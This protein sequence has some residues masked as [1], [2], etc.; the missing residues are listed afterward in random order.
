[1]FDKIDNLS[2]ILSSHMSMNTNLKGLVNQ[3]KLAPENFLMPLFEAVVNSVQSIEEAGMKMTS[4]QISIDIIRSNEL[5]LTDSNKKDKDIPIEASIHGFKI[6]DN[7]IGFDNNN[8]D[9]FQLLATEHKIKFGCKGFG[10]LT[11]LKVFNKIRIESIYKDGNQ[12]IKRSFDFN[13]SN[14][15]TNEQK[16]QV[17]IQPTKTT[18]ELMGIKTEYKNYIPRDIETIAT[19]IIEHCIWYYIRDSNAPN[20]IVRDGSKVI[21][22]HQLYE[23]LVPNLTAKAFK[24]GKHQFEIT[25]VKFYGKSFEYQNNMIF[26]AA[27]RIVEKAKL[28]DKII[29]GLTNKITESGATP[30]DANKTFTYSCFITSKFFNEH[31]NMERTRINFQQERDLINADEDILL[32]KDTVQSYINVQCNEFLKEYLKDRVALGQKK[33]ENYVNSTGVRYKSILK[34]ISDDE[35]YI[36]PDA[37]EKDIELKL[38]NHLYELEKEILT[39]GHMIMEPAIDE[40]FVQYK[41]RLSNYLDKVEDMKQSDL[42][43]YITHRKVII[44]IFRKALEIRKDGKY[45]LEDVIHE[46]IVPMHIDSENKD[47]IRSNLWLIDERLNFHNYMSSDIPLKKVHVSESKSQDRPDLFFLL[48]NPLLLTEEKSKEVSK[49]SIIIVEFKRPMRN[50]SK[51]KIE[52]P[53]RQTLRYL[54]QIKSEKLT[55]ARG[56]PINN[57]QDIPAY[58]FIVCDLTEKIKDECRMNGYTAT[59]DKEGYFYH[60]SSHRAYLEVISYK[61]LVQDAAKRNHAFFDK[62]GLPA[63]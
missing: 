5:A 8:F 11:W 4:G 10:R 55:D 41:E 23:G 22:L 1:M 56:R 7:G 51:L 37:S 19:R 40:E 20:I 6:T 42:T 2:F 33:V 26:C 30:E 28:N 46:L 52:N 62:L 44:D 39:E 9:S 54:D 15:V 25:H 45:P 13:A 18:I 17:E 36:H 58:C 53:M 3:F 59:P 35:K 24:I 63:R 61:K 14:G 27:D 38:H 60:N 47:F 29:L 49:E 16:E 31:V 21:N 32:S 12:L 57:V 34:R 48:D 50:D 43:G